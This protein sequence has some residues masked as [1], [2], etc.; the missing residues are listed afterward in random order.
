M[1]A[2][3]QKTHGKEPDFF[4]DLFLNNLQ[5]TLNSNV[6]DINM[7]DKYHDESVNNAVNFAQ[8]GKKNEMALFM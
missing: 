7:T 3:L 4:E 1:S 8:F 2:K 5:S 6:I